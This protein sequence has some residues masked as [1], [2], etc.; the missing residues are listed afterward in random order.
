[1]DLETLKEFFK[2]T[3]IILVYLIVIGI[4]ILVS[5]IL[6]D[7]VIYCDQAPCNEKPTTII[8]Q[9]IYSIISFNFEYINPDFSYTNTQF[10]LGIKNLL[11]PL[12]PAGEAYLLLSLI[13]GLIVH[14]LIICL[15][16][17]VYNIYRK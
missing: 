5:G 12:I 6:A 14:Y 10:A 9:Q 8:G 13:I 11:I 1:M 2:P 7:D 4:A 15:V 17:H 3:K 16:V